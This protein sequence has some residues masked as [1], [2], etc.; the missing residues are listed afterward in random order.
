MSAWRKMALELLPEYR[1]LIEKT[2]NPMVL[3]IDLHFRFED[4]FLKSDEDL[5]QRFFT[6]A[7]WCFETPKQGKYLSDVGTAVA[8]AFYEHLVT[9]AAVCNDLH[10]WFS[11]TEFLA[12]EGVF[13][14][15]LSQ[16][17]FDGLKTVFLKRSAEHSKC[18]LKRK[19]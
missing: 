8:V 3:W 18:S 6:Y 2:E 15:H 5:V 9:D 16:T 17:E 10:R 11:P 19:T 7:K 14:Y 12:L 1:Q 13:K 4:A